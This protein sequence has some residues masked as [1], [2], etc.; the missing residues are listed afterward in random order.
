MSWN[1]QDFW[2]VNGTIAANSTTAVISTQALGLERPQKYSLVDLFQVFPA[3]TK[4]QGQLR[5]IG[6]DAT[7]RNE[8]D[9]VNLQIEFTPGRLIA[10][11]VKAE[12]LVFRDPF[13][14]AYAKVLSII[15]R[16]DKKSKRLAAEWS[17]YRSPPKL[18]Y[19]DERK[20]FELTLPPNT[21][22]FASSKNIWS[23][24]GLERKA[25][26]IKENTLDLSIYGGGEIVDEDPTPVINILP[27]MSPGVN[28]QEVN[29]PTPT[30]NVTQNGNISNLNELLQ[31][32]DLDQSSMSM[33]VDD[34]INDETLTGEGL[35]ADE[36][37]DD[38]EDASSNSFFDSSV[39]PPNKKSKRAADD[40]WGFKN[41]SNKPIKI[42]GL[43]RE[44]NK[45]TMFYIPPELTARALEIANARFVV[46]ALEESTG[47][48]KREITNVYDPR[49]IF[50]ALQSML[51][52]ACLRL[53]FPSKMFRISK[54]T[55]NK[56][57]FRSDIVRAG[58]IPPL[59]LK[60][61][62]SN[63][64]SKILGLG[65]EIFY[66]INTLQLRPTLF[67]NNII[68][69]RD[70]DLLAVKEYSNQDALANLPNTTAVVLKSSFESNTIYSNSSSNTLLCYITSTGKLISSQS[71]VFSGHTN[72][73]T[74]EFYNQRADTAITWDKPAVIKFIF[75]RV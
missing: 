60:L 56:F 74:C 66:G 17:H 31:Q 29:Q 61:Q 24:F 3:E 16:V 32:V 22:M 34:N 15:G 25:S 11:A 44:R 18:L 72:F 71:F 36:T 12:T 70:T 53:N 41:K 49:Q 2:I 7:D 33:D 57:M 54:I 19:D 35:Q 59:Q 63:V 45:D 48:I 43:F 55:E 27:P 1:H 64:T 23:L 8:N 68:Y 42:T 69:I 50:N 51:E 47:P 28:E 62:F 65:R 75:K 14:G 46:Q 37:S 13:R 26:N 20:R 39:L 67:K 30:N 73:L 21:A 4:L 38:F 6:A 9:T 52:E 5:K 58:L 40:Q 10:E